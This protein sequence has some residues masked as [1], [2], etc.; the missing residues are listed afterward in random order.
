MKQKI[1][2]TIEKNLNQSIMSTIKIFLEFSYVKN[3][4]TRLG[5][6]KIK[7]KKKKTTNCWRYLFFDG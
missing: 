1:E 3:I 2:N 7:L 5:M 4:L 6:T